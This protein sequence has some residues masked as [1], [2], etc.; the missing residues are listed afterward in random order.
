[1]LALR[2]M[3]EESQGNHGIEQPL[4]QH[5]R[6]GPCVRCHRSGSEHR[7]DQGGRRRGRG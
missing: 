5:R 1:M 3:S 2:A 4:G 7:E 6:L